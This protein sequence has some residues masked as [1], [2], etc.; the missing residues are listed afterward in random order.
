[1]LGIPA[2][3]FLFEPKAIEAG[4]LV[5]IEK[6]KQCATSKVSEVNQSNPTNAIHLP[7]CKCLILG[8]RKLQN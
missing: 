1:M 2:A 8:P 5:Y 6:A 4:G 3:I 7:T